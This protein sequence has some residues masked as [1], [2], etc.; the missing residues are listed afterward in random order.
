MLLKKKIKFFYKKLIINIFFAVYGKIKVQKKIQK[1]IKDLE[2]FKIFK[3]NIKKYKYRLYQINK[4]IE[5]RDEYW[6]GYWQKDLW[7]GSAD[8][9]FFNL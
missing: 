1:E 3:S 9:P 5:V 7:L 2:N 4:R 6:T 8:S